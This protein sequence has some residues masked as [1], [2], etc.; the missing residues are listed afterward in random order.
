MVNDR[1]WTPKHKGSSSYTLLIIED[2]KCYKM[3][4]VQPASILPTSKNFTISDTIETLKYNM[5]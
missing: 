2:T 4:K 5:T 1:E 3:F